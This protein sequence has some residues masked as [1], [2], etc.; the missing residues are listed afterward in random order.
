MSDIIRLLPDSVANQIAAGEVIQRPASV[1]KELVENAIDAGGDAI[2]VNVKDAGR[3]LIQVTDNG[4]GMSPADARMSFERH[5]TSKIHEANDLFS[6]RTMGFRGEALA[7]IASVA[8]VELRTRQQGEELGT[9]LHILGSVLQKQQTDHC[10]EGSNFSVKNLFFNVPA[11]RKFLKSN[12]YELKNIITEIQRIALANPE[13]A[14]SFFHNQAPVYELPSENIR[15]RIVSLFGKTINQSLT[16]VE[17]ET[18]LVKLTGF[19]GQ[20]KF[21]KKSFGEQFFFVNGRFMKH[22]FFHRA[23]MQAYERILPPDAIPSYFLYLEVDPATI[24][25][26]IHP[27]KTEIKFE[28]EQAIWHILSASIREAIGKYNLMP[29]IDFDQR[30]SI[31]IPLLPGRGS[32]F[33]PPEIEVN[34]YYNPF[35]PESYPGNRNDFGL[36]SSQT[37]HWEKLYQG[38]ENQKDGETERRR[39]G[40]TGRRGNGET[41]RRG[42]GETERRRD[43]ETERRGDGET[44]NRQVTHSLGSEQEYQLANFMQL[45]N[46]YLLT[47]VKSGLMVID[48]REAHARILYENFMQN[49]N[50]HLAAS[51]RQL[52]PPVLELNAADAEILNALREELHQLGFDIRPGEENHFYIDGTPGVLSHLDA[53]E[54]VET[55]IASFQDRPVDLMEE[56][57]SQLALV[58]AQSSAV[59][60]GVSL[61]QE[62]MV[63]LFNQLFTCQSPGF[64]PTGRKIISIIALTDIENLLKS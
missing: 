14:I 37:G 1:V 56:I 9:F 32:S 53:K 30:G 6:I 5:A 44:E 23:V 38:M 8:E 19:I 20:P 50:S 21:A 49:F 63:S 55:V 22:P 60:Y 18:T 54:M 36:E 45:K 47:P 64:S 28:D 26:N 7:S 34:R 31:E 41:E 4:K 42:D 3:T 29:T 16:P 62:E 52:F 10:P 24:D 61:K 33:A 35:Q 43:G 57:K 25:I 59:N 51:Q 40:E 46:R 12:S 15:K 48:Q 13:L 17:T 39:D 11:R 2:T 58:L 27:T